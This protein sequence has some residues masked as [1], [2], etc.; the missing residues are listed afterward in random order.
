MSADVAVFAD[1]RAF[2][3]DRE[4]PDAGTGPDVVRLHIREGMDENASADH[5]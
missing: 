1:A 4:L 3:D 5:T 2:Q